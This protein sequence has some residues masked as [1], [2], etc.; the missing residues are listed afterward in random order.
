M[1]IDGKVNGA[2]WP[3]GA[4]MLHTGSSVE[5]VPDQEAF[6]QLRFFNIN[7]ME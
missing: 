6:K 4:S 7:P 1:A 2:I 5:P 3:I